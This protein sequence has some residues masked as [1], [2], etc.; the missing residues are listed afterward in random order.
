MYVADAEF[1]VLRRDLVVSQQAAYAPGTRKNLF[2]QWKSFVSFCLY[3]NVHFLPV[4]LEVFCAYAQF[5]SRSFKSSVSIRN[6]L[7]G[8]K[9][10][11]ILAGYTCTHLETLNLRL[12]LRGIARLHPYCAKKATAMSPDILLDIYRFLDL[13]DPL[14]VACWAAFLLAFFLMARKANMV[15]SSW[16]AFEV[17]KQ[18][19]R[20]SIMLGEAGLMV[21]ITWSKTNQFG[22]RALIVPVVRIPRSPLCPVVAYENLLHVCAAA[23]SSPAFTFG[24]RKCVTSYRFVR[25]LRLLLQRAG[26]VSSSFTGHSFRR[27][28]ATYAFKAGVPGELIKLQGDWKSSAYLH[29][30]DFSLH[31]KLAV[32]HLMRSKILSEFYN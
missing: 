2:T 16:K 13:Q 24:D 17:K 15:P 3:F 9:Q 29:Y 18:L 7:H 20:G 21:T 25:V 31:G 27:G 6:Y 23:D 10:L 4:S 19:S 12:L 30:L 14:H 1:E 26:Y 32:G 11:H 22:T 8:V 28:G 5:L